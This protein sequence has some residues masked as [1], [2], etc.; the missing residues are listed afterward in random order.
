MQRQDFNN[1]KLIQE[2]HSRYLGMTDK[3]EQIYQQKN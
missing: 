1:Y 2:E 3:I